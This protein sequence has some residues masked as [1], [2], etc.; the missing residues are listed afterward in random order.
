MRSDP[1]F[2]Q[3]RYGDPVWKFLKREWIPNG[4]QEKVRLTYRTFC[5]GQL[6]ITLHDQNNTADCY[7]VI[8]LSGSK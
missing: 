6:V 7:E 5:S 4:I 2:S 3:E 8:E 1:S